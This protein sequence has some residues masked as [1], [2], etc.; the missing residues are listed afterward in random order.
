MLS[1]RIR[2]SD[3]VSSCVPPAAV[4][5]TVEGGVLGLERLDFPAEHEPAR[6]HDPAIGGVELGLQLGVDCLQVEKGN[7]GLAAASRLKVS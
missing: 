5:G 4:R 6:F 7:H 1:S 2:K 3:I